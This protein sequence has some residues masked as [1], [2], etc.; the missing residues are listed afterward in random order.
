MRDLCVCVSPSLE[1][2]N[3]PV[4]G[5]LGLQKAGK[6]GNVGGAALWS[7]RFNGFGRPDPARSLRTPAIT[8]VANVLNLN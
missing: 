8:G 2:K 1:A 7:R 5:L 6:R 4:R 3:G